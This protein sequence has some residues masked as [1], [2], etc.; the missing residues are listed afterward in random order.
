MTR[1]SRTAVAV[2]A[3][4]L[5]SAACGG[6]DVA[7]PST[8]TG[9]TAAPTT[10]G[11]APASPSPSTEPAPTGAAEPDGPAF[12][13]GTATSADGGEGTG[14]SVVDVRVAAQDGYDRVVWELAGEGTAGWTVRYDD[15]PTREGSGDAVELDGDASLSLL[16]TGVGYPFD[17]GVP[18]YDGPRSLSPRL[19]S[20]RAVE[21][22]AV[23]EGQYDAFVGVAQQRPFRVLRLDDPQRV[24][25]DVRH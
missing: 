1:S 3:V 25:L 24:V 20:V 5:L 11:T 19:T 16:L 7:V 18:E 13:T 15:A 9:A 4:A 6:D 2:L 8:P 22:G 10:A 23:F 12:T 17:N 21:L 14:L